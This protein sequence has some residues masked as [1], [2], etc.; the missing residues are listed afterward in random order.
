M[1][2]HIIKKIKLN[3]GLELGFYDASKKIAGDRW[4]VKLTAKVEIP[5]ADYLGDMP[6]SIHPDDIRKVL[7]EQVVF[8]KD[9]ERNFID[10]NEKEKVF[11]GFLESFLESSE[12][13]LS[14]SNF[15]KQFGRQC[16]S[17]NSAANNINTFHL[18]FQKRIPNQ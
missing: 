6:S 17:D 10:D 5:V 8:E 3:N 12:K 15:P 2:N 9:M 14:A 13:Y 18:L 4:L 7:G 16:D 1:G 11:K